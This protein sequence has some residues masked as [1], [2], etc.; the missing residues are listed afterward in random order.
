M[1]DNSNDEESEV[2]EIKISDI[3]DKFVKEEKELNLLKRKKERK[4]NKKRK[5]GELLKKYYEEI[6]KGINEDKLKNENLL[7]SKMKTKNDKVQKINKI[8]KKN[9]VRILFK[10]KNEVY[11]PISQK[12]LDFKNNHFFGDRIEREKNFLGKI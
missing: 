11:N 1:D 3:K 8:Y 10:N 12:V 2:K 9:N 4:E 7:V 5:R 6:N